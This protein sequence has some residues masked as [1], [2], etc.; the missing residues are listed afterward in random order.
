MKRD[1]E[2]GNNDTAIQRTLRNSGVPT[3]MKRFES[4]GHRGYHEREKEKNKETRKQCDV[5][6]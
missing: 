1:K 4:R 5:L 3:R 2:M 6:E